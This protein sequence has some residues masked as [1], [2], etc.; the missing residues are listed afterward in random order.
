MTDTTCDRTDL[1]VT[2]C[3]HCRGHDQPAVDPPEALGL[4]IRAQFGG[5]CDVCEHGI[6]VDAEIIRTEDYGWV[7]LD[8]ARVR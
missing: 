3:A 7:H 1:P 8:C 6:P 4:P 5:R 2:M